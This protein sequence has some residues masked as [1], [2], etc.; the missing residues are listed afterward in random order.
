MGIKRGQALKILFFQS[1]PFRWVA[2]SLFIPQVGRWGSSVLASL[3]GLLSGNDWVKFACHLDQEGLGDWGHLQTGLPQ[4]SLGDFGLTTWSPGSSPAAALLFLASGA[5]V[6]VAERVD[7]P[8]N[9]VF[10]KHCSCQCLSVGI[11]CYDQSFSAGAL[12]HIFEPV[13][14]GMFPGAV[15]GLGVNPRDAS[16]AAPQFLPQQWWNPPT[17]E[18]FFDRVQDL[19]SETLPWWPS[20]LATIPVDFCN[21]LSC[22]FRVN[23][24]Y[25]RWLHLQVSLCWWLPSALADGTVIL[26][27]PHGHSTEEHPLQ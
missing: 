13:K 14:G 21:L 11:S 9:F 4:W 27:P 1:G 19:P 5:S 26:P 8:L 7:Q 23:K 22:W 18:A 10:Q 20:R 17:P 3:L 25:G 6:T 16:W 24:L 2:W 12:L 15:V